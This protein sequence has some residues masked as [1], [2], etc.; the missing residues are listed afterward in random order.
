MLHGIVLYFTA[1]NYDT[2]FL[3]NV[4]TAVSCLTSSFF[5]A[6]DSFAGVT[7]VGQ[8]VSVAVV[9]VS[10]EEEEMMSPP[11]TPTPPPCRHVRR[12]LLDVDILQRLGVVAASVAVVV[13]SK[14]EEEKYVSS[15]V[16]VY[17]S[18]PTG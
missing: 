2:Y 15:N 5:S 12:L 10:K 7:S 1:D 14:E 8:A 4:K 13:V 18:A 9:V 17:R 11:P 6:L 16:P 3:S